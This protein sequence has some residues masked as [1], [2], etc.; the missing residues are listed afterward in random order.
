MNNVNA[1]I[2]LVQLRHMPGVVAR[3]IDNGRFFD[4]EL[5]GVSGLTLIPYHP[6]TEPSYWLYTMRVENRDSFIRCLEKSGISA[7]PLHLRNDR[8]SVFMKNACELSALDKFYQELVHIP[9]GWWVTDE[10]RQHI[11]DTIRK[12]W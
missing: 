7:S 12:G 5:E 9:C 2:G 4:R 11:V 10:D 1:T 8:H 6:N 3:H